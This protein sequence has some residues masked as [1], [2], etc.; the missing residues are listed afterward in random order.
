MHRVDPVQR[1]VWNGR[2]IR[3]HNYRAAHESCG[4][5][6]RAHCINPNFR[7]RRKCGM[8]ANG[9]RE[10]EGRE[11]GPGK[12]S[13]LNLLTAL[14]PTGD[15]KAQKMKTSIS[16]KNGL[17]YKK[18]PTNTKNYKGPPHTKVKAALN[19]ELCR[20]RLT[21]LCRVVC[22]VKRRPIDARW[23]SSSK[24]APHEVA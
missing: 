17:K 2:C 20:F 10:S 12:F 21:T 9:V 24:S 22:R 4:M 23:P 1:P 15:S 5:V 18:P 13:F 7:R 3:H 11:L 14:I 19:C 6:H 16:T 8:N